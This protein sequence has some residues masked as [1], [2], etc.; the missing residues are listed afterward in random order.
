MIAGLKVSAHN[1]DDADDTK[2]DPRW[3]TYQVIEIYLDRV[4]AP[5]RRA[6]F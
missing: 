3:L 1:A 2:A 4:F 5:S 6:G